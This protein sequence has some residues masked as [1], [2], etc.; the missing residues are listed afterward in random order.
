MGPMF[1]FV[2]EFPLLWVLPPL[3]APFSGCSL[4]WG[5]CDQLKFWIVRTQ[6]NCYNF[7]SCISG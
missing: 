5:C 7:N 1:F 2:N 4:S 3:G 6:V